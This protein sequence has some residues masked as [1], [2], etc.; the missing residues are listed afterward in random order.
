MNFP[1]PALIVSALL[2]TAFATVPGCSS[3]N[4]L[5][6]T[7]SVDAVTVVP[8]TIGCPSGYQHPKVCCDNGSSSSAAKCLVNVDAPFADCQ[9]GY[10][11]YG[12]GSRCC[13]GDDLANC[14]ECNDGKCGDL[15]QPPASATCV[16]ACP[17]GWYGKSYDDIN[18]CCQSQAVGD[19][20]E[21]ECT[22]R[23]KMGGGNGEGGSGPDPTFCVGACPD[24]LNHD[25]NKPCCGLTN[26]PGGKT[27]FPLD[28]EETCSYPIH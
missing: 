15:P 25:P 8:A 20:F 6:N 13:S 24:D 4:Q 22:S 16:D 9:E 10:V 23:P 11:E 19:G 1:R 28:L 21:E 2:F 17:P 26:K 12:D 3:D 18:G 27:G 5:G 14:L 7:K